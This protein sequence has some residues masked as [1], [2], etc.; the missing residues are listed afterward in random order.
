MAFIPNEAIKRQSELTH[1]A[2]GLYTYYCFRRGAE[3]GYCYPSS[4]TA[5]TEIGAHHHQ[6]L[7]WL[8]ELRA[9]GWVHLQG[10]DI[11]PVC[12]FTD[13]A[14]LPDYIRAYQTP[15]PPADPTGTKT[16]PSQPGTK[17]VPALSDSRYENGTGRVVQKRS[18]TGTKTCTAYKEQHVHEVVHE[19][20]QTSPPLPP[21]PGA[22]PEEEREEGDSGVVKPFRQS[23][24]SDQTRLAYAES[25]KGIRSP[26]GFADSIRDGRKDS[27]IDQWLAARE[28]HGAENVELEPVPAHWKPGEAEKLM[29]ELG[30]HPAAKQLR[31]MIAYSGAA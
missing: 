29:A 27:E 31:E 1:G 28:R 18:Q 14:K 9:A 7:A 2:F 3:S 24:H 5:A 20:V 12:G 16:V 26:A 4:R 17:T 21:S 23:R 13:Q 8:T 19:G 10:K 11:Y 15:V 22:E 30:D 25:C 6:V